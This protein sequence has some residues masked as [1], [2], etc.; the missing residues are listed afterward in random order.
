MR[1][2]LMPGN[3]VSSWRPI[4]K[5]DPEA[6]PRVDKTG[7]DEKL[8]ASHPFFWAGYMVVDTGSR[9]PSDEAGK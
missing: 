4:V 8:T 9:P 7:W 5:L 1:R 3:G 6:E 2:P